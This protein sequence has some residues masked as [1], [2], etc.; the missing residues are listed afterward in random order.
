[1]Y[2]VGARPLKHEG[3]WL[4]PGDIVPG[5]EKWNRL[6]SWIRWRRIVE[7]PDEKPKPARLKKAAVISDFAKEPEEV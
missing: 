3:E 7:V 6:E 4:Q 1:M 5:A 2:I